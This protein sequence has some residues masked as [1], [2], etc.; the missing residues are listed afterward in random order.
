MA[1]AFPLTGIDED[2][3]APAL[4]VLSLPAIPS[5]AVLWSRVLVAASILVTLFTL[6]QL[7]RLVAHYWL[8]E[9]LGFQDVFWTNFREGAWLYIAAFVLYMAAA[10][11]PAWMHPI[12]GRARRKVAAFGMLAASVAAYFGAISYL[13]F[14]LGGHSVLPGPD[15]RFGRVDP[16]FGL[17]VGFYVFNLP[18]IRIAWRFLLWA[19][20]L[21]LCVSVA[22]ANVRGR[23]ATGEPLSRLLRRLGITGTGGTQLALA[24]FGVMAALGVW[25]TRFDLLL[26]DNKDSSVMRGAEYIDVNGFFSTLNHINLT[27]MVVLGVTVVLCLMLR[28]LRDAVNGREWRVPFR[29]LAIALA[30][31]VAL[32]FSFKAL[33][34]V[35]DVLFVRPNE[36]VIQ[37]PYIARHVD[38]TREAY[39]IDKIEER[40][41]MP[42]VP[43]DPLPSAEALLASPALRN[44]PLW[45]G[46][47]SYLERW[48]DR[49]HAQRILQTGNPMVYG[50]TLETFQQQQKLRTYYNFLGVDNVRY[51][52]GG[53]PRM[54]VSSVRETPLYEPQPWLAY[55]GQRFMLFT[56]GWG[57]VMAPANGV[58]PNGE[59]QYASFDIP[60]KVQHPETAVANPRV[61]YGEGA[62]TMAFSNVDRM[63]E[64]DYPT[65][66]DRA[67]IWLPEN[68][69][70]GVKMDSLLK[71]VV[72]GWRSGMF[73]DLVF[74]D[75]ITARTRAHYY[76]TPIER[77]EVI[78]PF[79]FYDSNPY[80]AAVDGKILWIVNAMST[81]RTFPYSLPEEL[82][83]KS[84]ERSPFPRPERWVNYVED[85]VKATVDA[86]TGE[87]RLY[88]I[89]GD[90]VIRALSKIY[91]ALFTGAAKMPEGVRAQLT[92][93]KQ[94][95]HIQ[96]DDLYVYY[97]MRDPMY[98]F[99]MEDMW[100]DA[101]EVLGPFVDSGRAITFSFEPYTWMTETGGQLP[102][103]SRRVQYALSMAFTPEKALNLRAIPIAYQDP[104]D[105]GKLAVLQVPKGRYVIGPEQADA[106]IDQEPYISQNFS[107]WTRKGLE[108]IRGHT[109]PLIVGRE[110]LYVEP[111]FL[112]SSQNPVPQLKKVIV[113]FRGKPYMADTLEEAVRSAVAGKPP[114]ADPSM[115]PA[116]VPAAVPSLGGP[117]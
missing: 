60:A 32:D 25:L 92:Y 69:S 79:L 28:R 36:P 20:L 74:S 89:S 29:R 100:D 41:F 30:A 44:A 40:Q 91:P 103:S 27:T 95:F 102:S 75:L 110:V 67:E 86:A 2:R 78:A 112:R 33:V 108:V 115:V 106:A 47:A 10:M 6:D 81:A 43:G 26:R 68:A 70:T 35:R 39:R 65:D 63:K 34:V 17:D 83:D 80:A 42:H 48:L 90:P 84:D 73:F 37:L 99:N 107:W 12:G 49:Q 88:A 98:F 46:Y 109:T 22:C 21:M 5:S 104:P 55:W 11:V 38:A 31:L 93:P 13:E 54:F 58:T 24:L 15:F 18:S 14:L 16:V 101:D 53:E 56:H 8:F 61:Y 116:A 82:G 57:L 85:S 71:R 9:S 59:P 23:T 3:E 7:T 77:L 117:A 96:F 64:L 111:I 97:H 45:P 52:V 50:P 105:Y 113:V 72:L 114:A 76:R 51:T 4:P 1:E 94:L 87:I 62:A 19:S 66:Q